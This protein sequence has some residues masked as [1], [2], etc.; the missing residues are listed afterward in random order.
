MTA[1]TGQIRAGAV[2]YTSTSTRISVLSE[3]AQ[4]LK[5]R[6]WRV[7]GIVQEVFT[8]KDGARRAVDAVELD[9]G[10]R[11]PLSR[12]SDAD[13]DAGLC[14]LDRSALAEATGAVRRAIEERVDLL[15]VEKFGDR[16]KKGEGL[17][18][19]ILLALAEGIPTL[20]LVSAT[21][22]DSWVRFTGGLGDLLPPE[23]AALWRWWGPRNLYHELAAGVA[24]A[25]VRRVI[26]GLHWTLVEGEMGC[27]LA[28]TP[29]RDAAGCHR[30]PE[31]GA[32]AGKNLAEIAR[33]AQSWNPFET[34]L[35][36]AA[37]NAQT[38]RPDLEGEAVSGLDL[39]AGGD[40]PLTVIGSFP[41]LNERLPGARVVEL[42]PREGE[43]PAAAA[44]W[45]LPESAAAVITASA[46]V[47]R[48]LPGLIEA[49]R[50]AHL[51]LIGPG[52]PLSPLLFAHGLDALAGFV[53]ENPEAVARI[54]TEG[55]GQS[56][57]KP[58]GRYVTLRREDTAQA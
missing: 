44:D 22:L 5:R 14:G 33:L 11:I 17:A 46:L 30:V 21:A 9:S 18:D 31:A 47:N 56:A 1:E 52:T 48:S 27:G 55:G 28:H 6:R 20:V 57:L 37:I 50:G 41:G 54:V 7:G 45:L 16:E 36:I 51:A 10:R 35:G 34:A 24:D 29:A 23:P 39:F 2:L 3:F 25:P 26:I 15:V 40:G 32:F 58:H 43:Y 8:R 53:V 38:N 4:E 19:E 13:I 42:E 49:G 12:P